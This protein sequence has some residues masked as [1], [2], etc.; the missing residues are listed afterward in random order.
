MIIY[1]LLAIMIFLIIIEVITVLFKLTGLTEE[2]ARFQVISLL[3]G[4]GFTTKESELITQHDTRRHLAQAVM[5]LG[6]VG[7]VTGISFFVDFIK[8]SISFENVI[9]VVICVILLFLIFKNKAFIS[10]FDDIVEDLIVKKRKGFKSSNKLYK[11]VT[12]AKGYGIFNVFIDESSPL[13]GVRLRDSNLKP[14]KIIILNIDKGN[15]FIGFANSQYIIES[16]DN[17]LLYGKI[18]EIARVFNLKI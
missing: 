17:I 13:I 3:T 14:H 9:V 7:L 8:S 18:S 2:K 16:G 11:L 12:R 1:F 10:W 5:L 6:Y 4:V 15:D